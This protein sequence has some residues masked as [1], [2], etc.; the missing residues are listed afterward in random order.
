MGAV[1]TNRMKM[2][3]LVGIVL[4]VLLL[5]QGWGKHFILETKDSENINKGDVKE[6]GGDYEDYKIGPVTTCGSTCRT[7]NDCQNTS[8]GCTKCKRVNR[9]HGSVFPSLFANVKIHNLFQN[10]LRLVTS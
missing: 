1:N 10:S 2:T 3:L 5:S 8:T 4:S 7:D 6:H 9:N